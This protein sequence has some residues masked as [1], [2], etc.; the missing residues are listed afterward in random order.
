M[1]K[2]RFVDKFSN[3][4]SKENN[5][6]RLK[7]GLHF[8]IILVCS[9]IS[10]S[11]VPFHFGIVRLTIGWKQIIYKFVKRRG[12]C[13]EYLHIAITNSMC[14]SHIQCV[15]MVDRCIPYKLVQVNYLGVKRSWNYYMCWANTCLVTKNTYFNVDWI[16]RPQRGILHRS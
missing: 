7:D 13:H 8:L 6:T 16:L 12:A 3:S 11:S 15:A 5:P 1:L 10:A 14:S 4:N 2:I 9:N